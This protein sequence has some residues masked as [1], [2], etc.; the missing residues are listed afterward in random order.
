MEGFLG[1]LDGIPGYKLFSGTAKFGS[2]IFLKLASN[3]ADN[4]ADAARL[5]RSLVLDEVVDHAFVK[6]VLQQGEFAGLGIRTTAQFRRHVDNV[7]SNPS[8]IRYYRD[9]RAVYLQESTR[10]VVI[11]NPTGSGQNTAFQPRDW[12]NYINNVLPARTTPFQ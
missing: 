1:S 3:G 7:L 4:I 6:H 9:G 12:S 2:T 8:S 5:N 11:R 10:T